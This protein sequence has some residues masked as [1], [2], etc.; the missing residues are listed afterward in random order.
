MVKMVPQLAYTVSNSP[1]MPTFAIF[2]QREYDINP[3][4][5]GVAIAWGEPGVKGRGLY[6]LGE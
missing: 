2:A 5:N 6:A 3:V 1:I 4:S